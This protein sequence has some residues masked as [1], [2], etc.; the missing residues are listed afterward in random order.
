MASPEEDS[1]VGDAL[2]LAVVR[3]V[4]K[5]TPLEGTGI[6][7]LATDASVLVAK[8]TELFVR[9]LVT[10]AYDGGEELSYEGLSIAVSQTSRLDILR[11]VVVSSTT[12]ALLADAGA[13]RKQ[14]P[15]DGE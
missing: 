7:A 4:A 14:P 13:P 11:D 3:R 2:P 12:A 15:P 6:R 5:A 8:A 1:S 10:L 9:D